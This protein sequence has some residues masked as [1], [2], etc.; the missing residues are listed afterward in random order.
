MK[1]RPP[2]RFAAPA[3]ILLALLAASACRPGVTPPPSNPGGPAGWVFEDGKRATVSD[4]TGKVLLLNFYATWCAPCRIEMPHLVALHR[5][6]E[7][8]GL[9]IIALNVGGEDDYAEVPAFKQEFGLPFPLAI[10]DNEFVDRYLGVNQN[11]PQ[12]FVID[13]HGRIVRH[14]IGFSEASVSEVETVV[15]TALAK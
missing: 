3:V 4:Y 6:Y 14:F 8:Q 9:Q 10:P 5:K 12:S 15:Q 11:I 7:S 1:M 13:R 2:I